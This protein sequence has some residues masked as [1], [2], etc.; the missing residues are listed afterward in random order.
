MGYFWFSAYKGFTIS[1]GLGWRLVAA[2]IRLLQSLRRLYNSHIDLSGFCNVA[3]ARTATS[4]NYSDPYDQRLVSFKE[5]SGSLCNCKTHMP[6]NRKS[7]W[8]RIKCLPEE[9]RTQSVP[10][11]HV[12]AS[13][14][15]LC[16]ESRPS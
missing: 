6:Q 11:S 16:L 12:P 13:P 14:E 3:Q 2:F 15:G 1:S 4:T 8:N 7:G 9:A 10:D 5:S